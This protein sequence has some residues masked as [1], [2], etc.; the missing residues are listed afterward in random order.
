MDPNCLAQ[1]KAN[2]VVINCKINQMSS[3]EDGHFDK[4]NPNQRFIEY[5]AKQSGNISPSYNFFQI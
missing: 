3:A 2:E 5:I 4:I 1:Q